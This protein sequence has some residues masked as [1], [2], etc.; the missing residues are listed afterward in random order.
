MARQKDAFLVNLW[1]ESRGHGDAQA[2]EWRGSV[3]H[4]MTQQRRYFT[5]IVELVTFLSEFTRQANLEEPSRAR[6][7]EGPGQA[8]NDAGGRP[9]S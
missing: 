8:A 1:F 5:E 2:P 6:E 4:L 7:A 3:E 9:Q